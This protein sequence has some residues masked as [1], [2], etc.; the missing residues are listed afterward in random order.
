MRVEFCRKTLQVGKICKLTT[1]KVIIF[2]FVN[3]EIKKR[4]NIKT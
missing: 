4:V 1:R 2:V 3:C